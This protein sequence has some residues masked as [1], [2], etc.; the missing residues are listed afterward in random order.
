MIEHG[1]VEHG[2]VDPRAQ[3]SLAEAELETGERA[4]AVGHVQGDLRH[5]A[6]LALRLAVNLLVALPFFVV[7]GVGLVRGDLSNLASLVV[8]LVGAL[9][10]LVGLYVTVLSRPRLGLMPNE[11]TLALRHP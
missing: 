4:A 7:G 8:M 6:A 2:D 11:G 10:I 1:A 3:P 5:P 9:V